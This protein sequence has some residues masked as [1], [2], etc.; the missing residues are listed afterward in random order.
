MKHRQLG[1]HG[2]RV[3]AIGLGCMSLAGAFGPTDR[4]T[5]LACLD[6][7]LA[8]GIT[9]Y[10]TA[11]VY[12][13]HVSEDILGDWLRSRR[14]E[15]VLAT[16]AG[17]TRDP[18]RPVD[19]SEAYLRAE[20]TGSLRR[21]GREK[22]DLFYAHRR[23]PAMPPEELAGIMGRFIDEG[24]I[25]GYGLSEIAPATLR[26]AHAERPVT[27]VQNEYSLWTRLPELGLIRACAELGVA[28]VPFSPLARGVLTDTPPDPAVFGDSDFRKPMPRFSADNYP[29]NLALIAGFRAFATT[30]GW[31]TSQAALAWVLD[32]GDHLVPIPGTRSAAHLA[33]WATASEI[34]LTEADRAEIARLLPPGFAHGDRYSEAQARTPERYC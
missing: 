30:R 34:T 15:V 29:R 23:D 24:L 22:V 21:L 5:S 10:D 28:F 26:R 17:I 1:T 14:P 8:A 19:N 9:F 20:L 18:A 25:G 16:K 33:H 3:S 32:Q 7:A 13:P 11:N 27:A 4:A 12:G 2:P 6:A 31:T